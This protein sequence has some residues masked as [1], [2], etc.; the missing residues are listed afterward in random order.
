M[1]V[2]FE[3]GRWSPATR[4]SYAIS[5]ADFRNW[6]VGQSDDLVPLPAKP[7]TIADFLTSRAATLS[8]STLSGRLAA[9]VAVHSLYGHTLDVK[10]SVIKDAWAEIR[11]QKGTAKKPKDALAIADIRR[12]MR[13]IPADRL[14]DRAVMLIGFGSAMRRSELIALDVEDL[15]FSP[16]DVTITIRRSKTDKT[17]KGEHVAVARSGTDMCPVAALEHWL[18]HAGITEGPVFRTGDN[19][20]QPRQVATITK[21]WAQNAGYLARDIGAHSLRRGCITTMHEAGIDL[22]SGMELSRHKT[23]TIYLGYV[24]AKDARSNPAVKALRV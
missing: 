12:I 21:R 5:W 18:A 3:R 8:T 22:K 15:E 7:Q 19:R 6:C 4:A 9:I 24:Q 20:M 11:R 23:P 13:G 1:Q 10:G 17:G 14:Q 2:D 16:E